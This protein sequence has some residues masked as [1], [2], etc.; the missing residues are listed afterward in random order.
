MFS[1]QKTNNVAIGQEF[2]M[3][4]NKKDVLFFL[5]LLPLIFLYDSLLFHLLWPLFSKMVQN[6]TIPL[7]RI[8]GFRVFSLTA[9][10]FAIL[11]LRFFTNRQAKLYIFAASVYIAI[12]VTW[13]LIKSS[14]FV[15]VNVIALTLLTYAAELISAIILII[16]F[17]KIWKFDR[18]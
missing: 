10:I 3:G 13:L 6:T 15:T 7:L 4:I 9:I 5:I 12:D 14:G 17:N 1:Q 11:T 2:I 18:Q 16:A 8:L